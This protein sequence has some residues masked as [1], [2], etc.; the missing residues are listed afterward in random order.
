MRLGEHLRT[1][2]MNLEIIKLMCLDET[3]DWLNV[4]AGQ[5]T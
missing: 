4:F 5:V 2:T 1:I 3:E